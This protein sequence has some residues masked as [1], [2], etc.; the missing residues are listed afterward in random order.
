[1][2]RIQIWSNVNCSEFAIRLNTDIADSFRAVTKEGEQ[3]MKI[4][5]E[6]EYLH[7][8]NYEWHYTLSYWVEIHSKPQRRRTIVNSKIEPRDEDILTFHA[9]ANNDNKNIHSEKSRTNSLVQE[10]LSNNSRKD[11]G[12]YKKKRSSWLKRTLKCHYCGL[13]F[14]NERERVNHEGE[15]HADKIRKQ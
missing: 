10:L 9:N 2:P 13:M 15:W 4:V 7:D 14:V 5:E 6:S 12:R 11:D 8:M 3:Y 1:M